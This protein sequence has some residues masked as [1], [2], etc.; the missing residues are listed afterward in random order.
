M[1]D[2]SLEAEGKHNT[3]L[4]LKF[5][6]EAERQLEKARVSFVD[7]T[8]IQTNVVG[9]EPMDELRYWRIS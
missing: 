1:F 3:M 7:G 9:A 2:K 4:R 8:H 5:T 6:E